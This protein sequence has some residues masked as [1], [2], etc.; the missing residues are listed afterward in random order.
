MSKQLDKQAGASKQA[1]HLRI[2]TALRRTVKS[3]VPFLWLAVKLITTIITAKDTWE[4]MGSVWHI[5]LI[6]GFFMAAWF[7][8]AYAGDGEEA[9]RDRK[10]S[11]YLA[12]GMMIV[13]TIIGYVAITDASVAEIVV[14]VAARLAAWG[15][16]FR[17]TSGYFAGIRANL[18]KQRDSKTQAQRNEA[19]RIKARDRAYRIA[20]LWMT[21]VTWAR[22][23]AQVWHDLRMDFEDTEISTQVVRRPHTST[24]TQRSGGNGNTYQHALDGT[25]ECLGCGFAFKGKVYDS[26]RSAGSAY[27]GHSR[28][29]YHRE[30]AHAIVVNA[31]IVA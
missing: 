12:W 5:L 20:L 31:E 23:A 24:P 1:L 15:A 26:L 8:V 6:D 29:A 30:N 28:S 2:D 13:V 11:A 10:T 4:V 17:D 21:P 19:R 18:R 22:S 3:A 25:L 14:N 16:L 7:S 27:S 9:K